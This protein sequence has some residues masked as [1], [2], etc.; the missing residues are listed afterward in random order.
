[1]IKAHISASVGRLLESAE[2]MEMKKFYNDGSLRELCMDDISNY[3]DSGLFMV[4]FI[5][6]SHAGRTP[7][8]HVNL[9]V[10]CFLES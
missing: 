3:R 10:G 5:S 6:L 1:M 7:T 4:S 9:M 2:Q 8:F